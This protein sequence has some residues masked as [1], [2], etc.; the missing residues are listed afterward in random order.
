[1]AG[2]TQ[3]PPETVI[4]APQPDPILVRMQ[5]LKQQYQ[6][7]NGRIMELKQQESLVQDMITNATIQAAETR[8]AMNE[9]AP[10]KG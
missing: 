1:M 2:K 6:Q 10:K 5:Q 4:E 9:I 8:G 3:E 7:I